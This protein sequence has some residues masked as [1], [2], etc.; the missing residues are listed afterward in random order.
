MSHSE[1]AAAF[2]AAA[3]EAPAGTVAASNLLAKALELETAIAAAEEIEEALKAVK[4]TIHRLATVDLVEAMDAAG[5]SDTTIAGTLTRIRIEQIVAGSLPKEPA[6]RDAAL[7][8]LRLADGMHLVKNKVE[9]LFRQSQDNEAK[10]LVA[11]LAE[12]GH[13]VAL[14]SDVHP[15]TLMAFGRECLADAKFKGDVSAFGL[16]VGRKAKITMAPVKKGKKR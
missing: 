1:V 15:Q 11:K 16:F 10:A 9:I 8:A 5:T 4:Q 12:E 7:E 3:S 2:D 14:I 13:A 6:A